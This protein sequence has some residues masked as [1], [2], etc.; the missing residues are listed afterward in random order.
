[1]KLPPKTDNRSVGGRFE[2]ELAER[3]S[4]YGAWVHVLQQN[5]AGQPADLI[6]ATRKCLALIDCKVISGP[7]GFRMSRIEENQRYAMTRFLERTG[8]RGW[9]ALKLPDG[10]IYFAF[11]NN[12]INGIYKD[13]KSISEE[14]IRK[15]FPTLSEFVRWYLL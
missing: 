7:G 2:Q 13:A 12:L 9:F 3:L 15:N 8:R 4:S 10:E 11:A 6:V 1:M 5:K 14:E